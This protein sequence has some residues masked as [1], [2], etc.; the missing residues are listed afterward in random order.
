[1]GGEGRKLA[2]LLVEL[3]DEGDGRAGRSPCTLT[4]DWGNE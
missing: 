4:Y 1:M 3:A 2:F